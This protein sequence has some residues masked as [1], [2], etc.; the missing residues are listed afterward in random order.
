MA[1]RTWQEGAVWPLLSARKLVTTVTAQT[2]TWAAILCVG[3]V[4]FSTLT[5]A[6]LTRSGTTGSATFPAGAIIYGAFT[7][8]TLTSGSVYC[9]DNTPE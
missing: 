9:Y 6:S 8:F 2:G 5:D 3:A 4:V 1:R 7:N